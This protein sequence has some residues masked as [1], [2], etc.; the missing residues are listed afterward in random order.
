M[1]INPKYVSNHLHMANEDSRKLFTPRFSVRYACIL[2]DSDT[3][4]PP[5]NPPE[6]FVIH[7]VAEYEQEAI[8]Y[9]KKEF[10]WCNLVYIN[11]VCS[12][13]S[14]RT[15]DEFLERWLAYD[16][17]RE[18]HLEVTDTASDEALL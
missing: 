14:V 4:Y 5:F 2:L 13:E 12:F 11:K 16:E 1:K 6:Y 7:V 9:V 3:E 10:P 17:L 8:D 15:D 18:H